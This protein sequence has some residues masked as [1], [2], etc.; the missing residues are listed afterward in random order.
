MILFTREQWGAK[1]GRGKILVGAKDLV[2]IHHTVNPD[3]PCG[4]GLK[5]EA[6]MMRVVEKNHAVKNKWDGIGYNWAAFPSGHIYEGRGWDRVGAHAHGNNSR[7]VGIVLFMNGDTRHPTEAARE[8]VRELIQLGLDEGH[9]SQQYDLVGH[10]D[11][12]QTECPGRHVYDELA[13][14]R[15]DTGGEG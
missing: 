4:A 1:H 3:V 10:R 13:S 12:W 15:P 14:F 5:V 8:A 6:R 2:V 9:I 7:S 11:V